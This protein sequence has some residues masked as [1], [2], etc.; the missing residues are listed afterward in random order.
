MRVC[1]SIMTYTRATR[2]LPRR[3]C[4]CCL[5]Q[6]LPSE[7]GSLLCPMCRLP[8][9]MSACFHDKDFEKELTRIQFTCC[10]CKHKVGR[11]SDLSKLNFQP[12][13]IINIFY[14]LQLPLLMYN[15]HQTTCKKLLHATPEFTPAAPTSQ[16][17]QSVT[18]GASLL[19]S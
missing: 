15:G 10:G 18:S 14:L 5:H 1:T 7:D 11:S 19:I 8:F 9:Q 17:P 4:E 2:L 6:T 12:F 3:F 16:Q 13:I